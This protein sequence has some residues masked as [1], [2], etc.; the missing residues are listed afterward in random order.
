MSLKLGK[1]IFLLFTVILMIGCVSCK[2][3]HGE[4]LDSSADRKGS[5]EADSTDTGETHEMSG[6]EQQDIQPKPNTAEI[7]DLTW[8]LG[9]V[10]SFSHATTPDKLVSGPSGGMYSYTDVFVVPKAG[11]TV[12]FTDDNTNSNGDRGYASASAYVVSS[13]IRSGEDWILN[14]NGIHYSGS[15][16]TLSEILIANKNGVTYSYTTSADHEAL[17]LC[18]R[19]G[20]TAA[21]RPSEYP[22][23][24]AQY[25]GAKGTAVNRL[26]LKKWIDDSK[27]DFYASELEGVTVNIL[28]D[29]YFAGNGLDQTY[30]WP[31]LL[32]QKYGWSFTNYGKNG[33]LV[34]SYQNKDSAPMVTR[35]RSM[36]DNDP[37]IVIL[38]GGRNDYNHNVPIGTVDS[39]DPNTFIGALNVIIGGVKE[40]Y[41]NAMILFTTVWNFTNTN[42]ASSL[43]YLDYAQAMV[44]VCEAQGVYCFHAYDPDVSG[45][46][47]RDPK[48]RQKYCMK[49]TDI[50][51]LNLDGMKLVMPNF[52]KFIASCYADFLGKQAVASNAEDCLPMFYSSKERNLYETEI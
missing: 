4:P 28:G 27:K 24:K 22:A 29:S 42:S 31:A 15:G 35:Y 44:A 6:T 52:E 50:S 12:T 30:V 45:V 23:V 1:W 40:K 2:S 3:S 32:A 21:F 10:A 49:P 16:S 19:S 26:A 8:H 38:N 34:S 25:T 17:R 13:W 5:G 33:G 46:N 43:T 41:P 48:F 7:L 11:T 36:R 51:H 37:Q 14:P 39:T 18:Y 9:Y 20:E 47:M